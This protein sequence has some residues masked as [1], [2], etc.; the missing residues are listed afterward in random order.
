MIC[1]KKCTDT[2]WMCHLEFLRHIKQFTAQVNLKSIT[3]VK[4]HKYL[5]YASPLS[6]ISD[7][8]AFIYFFFSVLESL[9]W[10]IKTYIKLDWSVIASQSFL[11]LLM[12]TFLRYFSSSDP[13]IEHDSRTWIYPIHRSP[14]IYFNSCKMYCKR[15]LFTLFSALFDFWLI[16]VVKHLQ[17]GIEVGVANLCLQYCN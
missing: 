10:G 3:K 5:D 12:L 8:V 11:F 6:V 2:L 14:L 16:Y 9:F 17:W 4:R 13:I 1:F 15:K 7:L